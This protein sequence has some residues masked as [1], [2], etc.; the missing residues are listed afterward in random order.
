LTE[1]FYLISGQQ[2][3]NALDVYHASA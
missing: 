3:N 1:V 2:Y